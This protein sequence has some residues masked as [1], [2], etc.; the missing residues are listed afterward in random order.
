MI[1]DRINRYLGLCPKYLLTAFFKEYLF[2]FKDSLLFILYDRI[3]RYLGQSPKYL[4][5]AF[6]K[7]YL[8]FMFKDSL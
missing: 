3:N 5:T 6:F 2:M 7:D 4:L 1:Y 8:L